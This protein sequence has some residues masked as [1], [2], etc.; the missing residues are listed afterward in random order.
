MQEPYRAYPVTTGDID[1]V[2]R[3]PS[4]GPRRI[5]QGIPEG[6]TCFEEE[7]VRDVGMGG[8]LHDIRKMRIPLKGLHKTGPLSDQEMNQIRLH[9]RHGYELLGQGNVS[10][11]ILDIASTIMM[12]FFHSLNF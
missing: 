6:P 7:T 3:K 10:R 5:T 4:A 8:L 9:P 12:Q 11:V 1:L 2:L